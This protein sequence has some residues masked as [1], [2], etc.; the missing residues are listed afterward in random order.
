MRVAVLSDIHCQPRRPST[1]SSPPRLGRCRLASR[2]RRRLRPRTRRRRRA[3]RRRSARSASR[4]NH[5]R[6]RARRRRDRLVQ[7]RCP[8]G[9]GVDPRR[10]AEPDARLAGGPAGRAAEERVHASSTA[11]RATRSGSTSTSPAVARANLARPDDPHRPARPHPR[12][13]G[14]RRARRADRADRAR[15]TARRVPAS[16]AGRRSSTRAASASPGTAIRARA[17]SMLD[18]DAG[19]AHLAP[20]RLRHRARSR[21]RCATPACRAGSSSAWR[22]AL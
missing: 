12:P 7:P 18:T 5:D 17:S 8:G 6:R 11:A 3:P 16:T 20:R 14:L 1:R 4:G 13:D 9:D 15:R 22:S 2:R 21:R 19:A 10:I